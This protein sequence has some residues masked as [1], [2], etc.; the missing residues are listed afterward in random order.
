MSRDKIDEELLVSET[1]RLCRRYIDE[2]VLPLG[3]CPWAAP[4]IQSKSVQMTVITRLIRPSEDPKRAARDVRD[5][6]LSRSL[7]SAELVLLLLPRC[8]YSRLQM[9]DLLR[10]VR[11]LDRPIGTLHAPDPSPREGE[12]SFALAAFHP[13]APRDTTTPERFITYLRRTPDPMIQAVR[14]DVLARI[15]TDQSAGT[16]YFDLENIDLDQLRKPARE[17]LRMRI[18]RANLQTCER[19]GLAEL[20]ARF[21]SILEDRAASRARLG[22]EV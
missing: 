12:L 5:A 14:T 8:G 22:L 19:H 17:P 1:E 9:D 11:Q 13:D 18:A 10:E 16:A 15:D 3:L 6:L 20:H 2:I 7:E 21:E 4:A